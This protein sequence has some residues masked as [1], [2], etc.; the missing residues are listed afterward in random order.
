MNHVTRDQH[1]RNVREV[2][3][4]RGLAASIQAMAAPSFKNLGELLFKLGWKLVRQ[5]KQTNNESDR[6]G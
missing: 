6:Q 2:M 1:D 5:N 4:V 3:T